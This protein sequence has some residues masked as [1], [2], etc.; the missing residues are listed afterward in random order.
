LLGFGSS[1]TVQ[2][3]DNE[4]IKSVLM[5]IVVC[6]V[7]ND[8]VSFILM[9]IKGLIL[10]HSWGVT[11]VQWSD[12]TGMDQGQPDAIHPLIS[13]LNEALVLESKFQPHLQLPGVSQV[14]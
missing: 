14:C 3:E 12:I 5:E 1:Y 8:N 6:R 7:I 11:G 13:K 4:K 10:G 9:Q 2:I